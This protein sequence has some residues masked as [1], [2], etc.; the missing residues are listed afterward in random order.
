VK[1]RGDE[2]HGVIPL[3]CHKPFRSDGDNITAP[4]IRRLEAEEP[5]LVFVIAY[6][7]VDDHFR[8]G[9]IRANAGC[10][11]ENDA[12]GKAFFRERGEGTK[13]SSNKGAA[14]KKRD[15]T[16]IASQPVEDNRPVQL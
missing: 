16:T 4:D 11:S 3:T 15:S 2:L 13:N 8:A 1:I 7:A 5:Y 14:E 6:I 12:G 9:F 10:C